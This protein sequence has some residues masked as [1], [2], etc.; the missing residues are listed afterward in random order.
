MLDVSLYGTTSV[1]TKKPMMQGFQELLLDK[2]PLFAKWYMR[3]YEAIGEE[4]MT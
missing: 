1:F 2:S 4:E 3:M